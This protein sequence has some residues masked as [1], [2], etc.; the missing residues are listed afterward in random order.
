[1]TTSEIFDMQAF[2]ETPLNHEP[3]DYLIVQKFVKP[4]MLLKINSDYPQINDAG[5]L[6]LDQLKYGPNFQAM[7]DALDSDEF[8][9]AFEKKFNIDLTDRPSTITARG[10]C[11]QKDGSIHTD[12][13]TKIITVLLYMNPKWDNS[14][15]QLRVLRSGTNIEDYAAEVKPAE[16]TLLAFLRSDKSWHGHLPF[17]GPRRVIQFNWVTNKRSQKMV[18]IR[19]GLSAAL[20]R[21]LG[22]VNSPGEK[23]ATPM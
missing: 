3:Y 11:S 23:E 4:E 2:G 20:K 1:M 18:Q 13:N 10:R 8:R 7:A 17:V 16:G 9:K 22:K 5:S 14:G 15:G 19:H 21:M 12:S 6:P